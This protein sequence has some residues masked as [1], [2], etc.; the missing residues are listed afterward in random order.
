MI[1]SG[2]NLKNKVFI[3]FKFIGLKKIFFLSIFIILG[4]FFEVIGIG[5]IGPFISMLLDDTIISS[6]V[7]LSKIYSNVPT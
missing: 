3:L 7:Y 5:L 6:N 4:S 1:I 2:Q